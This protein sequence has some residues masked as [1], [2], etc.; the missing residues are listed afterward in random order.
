MSDVSKMIADVL[1]GDTEK[2]KET[3]SNIM[4]ARAGEAIEVMKQVA[5]DRQFNTTKDVE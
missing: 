2:A 1:Q 4:S 3:F 5:M